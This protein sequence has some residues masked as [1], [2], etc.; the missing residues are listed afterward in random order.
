M[1]VI[2]TSTS[3]Q[4]TAPDPPKSN[5]MSDVERNRHF[6]PLNKSHARTI[7]IY[8]KFKLYDCGPGNP[9]TPELVPYSA[10]GKYPR[11]HNVEV[12]AS[13]PNTPSVP[14]GHIAV[15][16]PHAATH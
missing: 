10:G 4:Q 6:L 2:P 8:R 3:Q 12:P 9:A 13:S 7:R 5:A 16:A 1:S 11:A 14:G 15:H